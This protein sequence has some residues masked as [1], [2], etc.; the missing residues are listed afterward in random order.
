MT[1]TDNTLSAAFSPCPND[2]FLF[3]SFL[4]KEEGFDILS[5]AIQADIDAL[6]SMASRHEIPLLK[7]SAAHYPSVIKNYQMLPVGAAVG[8]SCGPLLVTKASTPQSDIKSVAVPGIHTTAAALVRIFYPSLKLLVVPYDK[9]LYAI[10]EN[11]VHSGVIIHESRFSYDKSTFCVV[12]DLGLKWERL[13]SL[14][15]P[16]GCLVISRKVS[17]SER[18]LITKLLQISLNQS[19]NQKKKTLYH[20]LSNTPKRMIPQL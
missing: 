8:F 4:R 19:L 14:P 12:E 11:I 9:I 5:D 6:N 10:E 16:L 13:T 3:R 20:S 1:T 2:I 18:L 7:I 15:V 17:E